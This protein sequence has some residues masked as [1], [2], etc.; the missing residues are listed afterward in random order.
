MFL[1]PSEQILFH[2][3][4]RFIIIKKKYSVLK[5]LCCCQKWAFYLFLSRGTTRTVAPLEQE[6]GFPQLPHVRGSCAPAGTAGH[7]QLLEGG[8]I[9]GKRR[10]KG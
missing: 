9:L 2:L 1:E 6:G 7:R 4:K 10:F 5:C 3:F 8:R